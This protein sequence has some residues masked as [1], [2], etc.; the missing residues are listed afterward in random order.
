MEPYEVDTG[1][2]GYVD[3]VSHA[4]SSASRCRDLDNQR[5]VGIAEDSGVGPNV[6]RGAHRWS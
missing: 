4:L 2:A 6:A 1:R 3:Q 5:P